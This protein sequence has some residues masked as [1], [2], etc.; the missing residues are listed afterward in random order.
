MELAEEHLH[1]QRLNIIVGEHELT[2][3]LFVDKPPNFSETSGDMT[4]KG[5]SVN[6]LAGFLGLEYTSLERGYVGSFILQG[7][8][9]ELIL[10]SLEITVGESDLA[11]WGSL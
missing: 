6:R 2:G 4:L 10:E 8:A 7:T 3:S 1:C 9:Q 11:G 5:P